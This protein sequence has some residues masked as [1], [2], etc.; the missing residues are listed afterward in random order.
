[1]PTWLGASR[2]SG[3]AVL[4]KTWVAPCAETGV[5]GV[6]S[7]DRFCCGV[8]VS[9]DSG[10]SWRRINAGAEIE[11][12]YLDTKAVKF[13]DRVALVSS[14]RVAVSGPVALEDKQNSVWI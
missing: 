10:A 11:A 14:S 1:M 5:Q 4:G 12:G 3:I 8:L 13:G 9:V 6:Y 7:N 2:A